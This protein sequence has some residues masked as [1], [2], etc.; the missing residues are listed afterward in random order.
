MDVV[1]AGGH[2]RVG[3]RLLALLVREGH[4]GRGLIRNPEQAA[5]LRELG[6]EA[7]LCDLEHDDVGDAIEAA[8]A[9]VYAAGAGPGSGP[10]R[11]WTMDLGGARKLIEAAPEWGVRRY[12]MVSSMGADAGAEDDGAFGTYLKAKGMADDALR[13]SGLDW[14]VV[15][16]GHLTDDPGTGRVALGER[17]GRGSVARDDV[18]AVL[19]ATLTTP[20]TVGTTFDLLGGSTPIPEALAALGG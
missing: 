15:R 10:Q 11:K 7:L 13:A 3:Q 14:T 1:V 18:A 4:R 9:I 2:G 16:P 6:A 20:A 8:D 5:A 12:V 19:L 17:L